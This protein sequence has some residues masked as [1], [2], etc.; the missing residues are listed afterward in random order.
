ME[1]K[2]HKKA[3]HWKTGIT[4]QEIAGLICSSDEEEIPEMVGDASSDKDS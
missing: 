2:E 3:S 1:S 4:E